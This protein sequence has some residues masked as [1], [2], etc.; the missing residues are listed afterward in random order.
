LNKS[1]QR[2]LALA[3]A[4]PRW[5]GSAWLDIINYRC[6]NNVSGYFLTDIIT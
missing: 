3:A 5:V 4:A 1:L 2:A 6:A